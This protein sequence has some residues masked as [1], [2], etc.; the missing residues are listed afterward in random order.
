MNAVVSKVG[1]AVD[2]VVAVAAKAL[3]SIFWVFVSTIGSDWVVVVKA[4][5]SKVGSVVVAVAAKAFK[6]TVL[7]V[8]I[9]GWVLWYSLKLVGWS[10]AKFLFVG[11]GLGSTNSW[12]KSTFV[13]VV[14]V[15]VAVVVKAL[16]S[17]LALVSTAGVEA[18]KS[19]L[20]TSKLVFVVSTAGSEGI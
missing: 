18:V 1:I 7:V 11:I 20:L 12:V 2:S 3:R 10:K 8:S 15:V 17:K 16:T 19:I 5:A 14:V 13:V 6:S 9:A 4:V